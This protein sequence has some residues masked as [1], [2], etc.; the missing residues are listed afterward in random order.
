MTPER[1]AAA[2]LRVKP[3]EWEYDVT[4]WGKRQKDGTSIEMPS[5]DHWTAPT[6]LLRGSY[7]II[8]LV[9]ERLVN[10]DEQP[11]RLG[12]GKGEVKFSTLEA[13][14]AAAQADYEARILAAL[15]EVSDE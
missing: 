8:R 3:L 15:E 11:F 1:L 2:G 13:A 4:T 12:L 10:K 6:I 5:A 7:S 9:D 14:K